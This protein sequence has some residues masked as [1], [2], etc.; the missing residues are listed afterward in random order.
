MHQLYEK[1][2]LAYFTAATLTLMLF[3]TVLFIGA[4][5]M[6]ADALISLRSP[7]EEALNG[8]GLLI[9]GFAVMETSK[10]IAEEEIMRQREL[11]SPAE[12]RRSLTK[13]ITIIVIATS[14]EA[15]VMVFKS[16]Q[17]NISGVIFPAALLIAAMVA[18]AAL[19]VYQWLSSR[20]EPSNEE[21]QEEKRY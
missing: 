7:I 20:I 4:L 5:W 1:F 12:S 6:M 8:I 9:I 2:A 16:S 21:S 14:L 17:E 15:L 11:R 3:C 18:L 10:F 19:G 13:F